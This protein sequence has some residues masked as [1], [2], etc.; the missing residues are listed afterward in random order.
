MT[1]EVERLQLGQLAT[2]QQ[3]REQEHDEERDRRPDDD[4]HC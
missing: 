2:A 1:N 3:A 4:V